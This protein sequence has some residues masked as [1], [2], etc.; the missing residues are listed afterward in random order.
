ML[1]EL[2][3]CYPV[4][5]E[6]KDPP[7]DLSSFSMAT[8]LTLR[9]RM[10]HSPKGE[11]TKTP[12]QRLVGKV[13]SI[14]SEVAKMPRLHRLELYDLG[15]D[16]ELVEIIV[17]QERT[18]QN[19]RYVSLHYDTV[20][21]L[22]AFKNLEFLH[23]DID[24]ENANA[25][26]SEMNAITQTLS[27]LKG[28]TLIGCYSPLGM[29]LLQSIGHQL[30]HLELHYVGCG[31]TINLQHTH[32]RNLKEF[33]MG[34]D[35]VYDLS[36]HIWKTVTNLE[37]AKIDFGGVEVGEGLS[38]ITEM[39]EKCE[40]LEYLEIVHGDCIDEILDA[41]DRG[42]FRSRKYERKRLKISIESDMDTETEEDL[43]MKFDRIIHRLQNHGCI[44]ILEYWNSGIL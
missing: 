19:V 36:S 1:K 44:G 41:M 8:K 21:S 17:N 25:N 11:Q 13:K 31:S 32:F 16:H 23:L 29:Q 42:L 35:C 34:E 26:D 5:S 12:R 2:T 18:N 6:P 40:N 38:C 33:V 14:A 27:G 39:M 24:D 37:K 15:I 43:A 10:W 22:T 3:V 4:I 7:L 30:Q 9:I 20:F 28:L